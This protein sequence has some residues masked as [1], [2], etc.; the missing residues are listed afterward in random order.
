MDT[1]RRAIGIAVG[2]SILI[3]AVAA[4]PATSGTNRASGN[5]N[6]RADLRLVS[7]LGA[8]PPGVT[9]TACAAR[10]GTGLVSGLGRVTEAYTFLANVDRPPCNAGFGK[11]LAYPISFV[12]AG[13]GEIRFSLTEG[14]QCVGLDDVRTQTQAFTVIA[15]TGIYE[16]AS[17]S[18]MVERGL[19]GETASGRVGRETWTGTLDV[20]GL[21]FDLTPPVVAGAVTK[22][23]QASRGALSARVTYR[24][25]ARDDVDGVVPVSC[26]PK[27]GGRFRIGRTRVTCSST[28]TSG[29]TRA[30]RFTIVV[31]RRELSSAVG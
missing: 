3:G 18:G 25:N 12:V 28:D 30:A 16:G 11:A 6:L 24:V 29:N 5:L 4:V 10:T 20:P 8:C 26:K 14:A 22:R 19:G 9:A 1:R 17:G 13:K 2:L 21:D 31:T 27:S 23:V 15:G 7:N